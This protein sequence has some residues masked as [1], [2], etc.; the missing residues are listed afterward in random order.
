MATSLG[1]YILNDFIPGSCLS[2]SFFFGGGT[3]IASNASFSVVVN[4][5]ANSESMSVHPA[6]NEVIYSSVSSLRA[7]KYDGWSTTILNCSVPV[8]SVLLYVYTGSPLP[9]KFV[10][11]QLT[12]V[13]SLTDRS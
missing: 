10:D 1:K 6:K 12:D 3:I 8:L 9:I 7:F 4:F 2:G 13:F 11:S 5:L